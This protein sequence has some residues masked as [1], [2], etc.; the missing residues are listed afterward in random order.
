[1]P[2][3]RHYPRPSEDLLSQHGAPQNQLYPDSLT[4]RDAAELDVEREETPAIPRSIWTSRLI[5]PL[6]SGTVL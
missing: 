5:I 4:L 6:L 3:S 1:M 2:P